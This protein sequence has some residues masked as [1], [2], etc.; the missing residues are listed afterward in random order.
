VSRR[1]AARRHAAVPVD[2]RARIEVRQ[3]NWFGRGRC[4]GAGRVQ[5]DAGHYRCT[6]LPVVRDAVRVCAALAL[7]PDEVARPSEVEGV[8]RV[9]AIALVT[10]TTAR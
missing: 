8:T 3:G 6:E 7:V 9:G 10:T 2:E 5:R 1:H 4:V